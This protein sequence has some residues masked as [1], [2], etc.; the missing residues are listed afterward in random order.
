VNGRESLAKCDGFPAVPLRVS[1][2]C[3]K[4]AANGLES[5]PAAASG[6]GGGRRSHPAAQASC[7]RSRR[8]AGDRET[9]A[10][11]QSGKPRWRSA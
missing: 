7:P 6:R 10:P 1:G 3:S 8:G 4:G 5:A 9:I 11:G 2:L